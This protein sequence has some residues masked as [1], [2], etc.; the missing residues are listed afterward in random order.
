M[1]KFLSL[2]A[3]GMTVREIQA[4]LEE[5]YCAEILPMLTSAVT[6][7]AMDETKAWQ[8]RLLDARY[9]IVYLDC[10][11]VKSRD[12]GAVKVKAVYLVLGIDLTGHMQLLG[13][14]VAQTEGAQF[15]RQVATE[16]K[17]RSVQDIFIAFVD[18][19]KGFPA[20]IEPLYPQTAVQLCVLHMVRYS[21]NYVGWRM[22]KA[23]AADLR[24][25]YEA[26]TSDGANAALNEFEQRWG[27]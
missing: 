13:L 27:G 15:R 9:L 24:S 11:D 3:R 10:I 4:H 1:K 5:M 17:N 6:D 14:W 22:R 21:L 7:A 19:L 23:V 12:T 18:G 25:V 16:L 20:A 26:A 8:S 2:Y